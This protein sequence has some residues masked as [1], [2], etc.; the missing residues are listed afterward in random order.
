MCLSAQGTRADYERASSLRERTQ[1]LA[2]NVVDRAGWIEKTSRFW[3]RK[4]VKGGYEFDI[5]DAKSLAKK[6]AFDHQKLAASLSAASGEDYSPL[7]L[8]FMALTFVDNEEAIEF[9]AG[10]YRWRCKLA[11]YSC[12]KI[13]P[14]RW[15]PWG[16][17]F[18]PHPAPPLRPKDA[19]NV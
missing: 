2:L 11:D 10:E 18:A 16:S 14:A 6:P 13:G 4:T 9:V 19:E 8:P 5:M 7:N 12:E 1:F 17:P 3:Y 15:R